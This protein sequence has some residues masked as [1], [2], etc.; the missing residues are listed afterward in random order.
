MPLGIMIRKITDNSFNF[1]LIQIIGLWTGWF[2]GIERVAVPLISGQSF[3]VTS[4]IYILSFISAF[5][6]SKSISNGIVGRLSDKGG[7]KKYILLG[8]IIGTPVPFIFLFSTSWLDIVVLNFVIGA[9]QAFTW[10]MAITATVDLSKKEYRGLSV[11]INEAIGYIGEGTAAFITAYL[12]TIVGL[13][14]SIFLFS[15]STVLVSLLVVK[16]LVKDTRTLAY[17]EEYGSNEIELSDNTAQKYCKQQRINYAIISQSGFFEKFGDV[18]MWGLFPIMLFTRGYGIVEISIFVAIYQFLWGIPQIFTGNLSDRFGRG[19]I[20]FSG[21]II[22]SVSLIIPF[23]SINF[24]W[25]LLCSCLAGIGMS[26]LYPTLIAASN[27]ISRPTHRGK[28]MGGY[29]FWRDLGYALGG[30]LIG[31]IALI[32]GIRGAFFIVA[33]I[34]FISSLVFISFFKTVNNETALK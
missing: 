18:L 33:I 31:Y 2:L 26:L 27:D 15:L 20:I 7:R 6:I 4:Y 25:I 21:M 11:G 14:L 13:K 28:S 8:W 12:S 22:L 34:I 3:G 9:S 17:H 5:G 23:Y 10:T 1:I 30:V 29:R 16:F 19:D 32:Y 24:W